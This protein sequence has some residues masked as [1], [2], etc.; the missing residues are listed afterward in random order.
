MGYSPPALRAAAAVEAAESVM[1]LVATALAGIDTATGRS[2]Q[3][4]S[5]IA[6]TL[7]GVACAAALAVVAAGL[8]RA[9][10][11]SRTPAL[12]TQLFIGIVGIYLLQGQR[13]DW[14]VPCVVL[15]VAGFGT[16]LAPPSLRALTGQQEAG[17]PPDVR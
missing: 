16:L 17:N 5:G 3:L 12:L 14:G 7:I 13:L 9:R 4:S 2:Y 15:A 8:A 10:R 11:W 6:L 1:V